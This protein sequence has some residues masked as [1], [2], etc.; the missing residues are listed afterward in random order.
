MSSRSRRRVLAGACL[1]ASHH[2]KKRERE[3]PLL[4]PPSSLIGI[5]RGRKRMGGRPSGS[6]AIVRLKKRGERDPL[7][8]LN[9]WW[10]QK[11]NSPFFSFFSPVFFSFPFLPGFFLPPPKRKRGKKSPHSFT[12]PPLRKKNIHYPSA[13]NAEFHTLS[14]LLA[15]GAKTGTVV[16]VVAVAVASTTSKGRTWLMECEGGRKRKR[17]RRKE[18]F[19]QDICASCCPATFS[20]IFSPLPR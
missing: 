12:P 13:Y 15:S 6:E 9:G 18:N 2:F 19:I 8:L 16:V 10:E 14:L 17:I 7:L 20:Y 11:G 4:P 1:A 5:F 3:R